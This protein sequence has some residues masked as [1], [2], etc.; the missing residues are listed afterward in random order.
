MKKEKKAK[1]KA[2]EKEN[3]KIKEDKRCTTKIH[4]NLPKYKRIEIKSRFSAGTSR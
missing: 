2:N 1:G 4:N 3:T